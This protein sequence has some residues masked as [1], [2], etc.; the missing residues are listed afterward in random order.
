[1]PL[2]RR[3]RDVTVEEVVQVLVGRDTDHHRTTGGILEQLAGVPVRDARRE[4]L[5]GRVHER[6][7]DRVELGTSPVDTCRIRPRSSA[8]GSTERVTVR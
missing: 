5:Q 2:E 3:G 1:M 8:T 6:V 7:G 4:F